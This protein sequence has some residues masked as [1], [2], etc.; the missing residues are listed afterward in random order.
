MSQGSSGPKLVAAIAVAAIGTL[1]WFGWKWIDGPEHH[2]ATPAAARTSSSKNPF[3]VLDRAYRRRWSK[4]R[5]KA[6]AL[7]PSQPPGRGPLF[8]FRKGPMLRAGVGE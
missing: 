4:A 3:N 1:G 8:S 5:S 2:D 7:R 6:A